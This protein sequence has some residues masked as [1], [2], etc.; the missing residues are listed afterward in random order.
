MVNL[1][2]FDYYSLPRKE[3]GTSAIEQLNHIL[4]FLKGLW[5]VGSGV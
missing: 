1:A 2:D 5:G 3:L 4:D